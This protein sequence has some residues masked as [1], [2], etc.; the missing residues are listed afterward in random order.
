MRGS[1]GGRK[2]QARPQ[3]LGDIHCDP[4]WV[5]NDVSSVPGAVLDAGGVKVAELTLASRPAQ[6]ARG[7]GLAERRSQA[8]VGAVRM[9][10]QGVPWGLRAPGGGQQLSWR[11]LGEGFQEGSFT[12]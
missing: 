3:D 12:W 7:H 9:G 2:A 1:R 10:P 4:H 8:C 6:R 11:G 5:L